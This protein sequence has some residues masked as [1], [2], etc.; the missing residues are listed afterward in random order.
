MPVATRSA[1]YRAG[2]RVRP[3]LA[4]PVR[5][6]PQSTEP[7][8]AGKR[9]A[10]LGRLPIE[11]V[12][13][14]DAERVQPLD[15]GLELRLREPVEE[16]DADRQISP[17][18]LGPGGELEHIRARLAELREHR[19]GVRPLVPSRLRPCWDARFAKAEPLEPRTRQ[20]AVPLP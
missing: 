18:E 4:V 17:P 19:R 14:W 7:V 6:D 3:S 5:V 15:T 11:A 10:E 2:R 8:P 1:R 16:V 13:N 12:E 20:P 9:C